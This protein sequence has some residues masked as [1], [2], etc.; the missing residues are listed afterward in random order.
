[1][2]SKFHMSF[3]D[4]LWFNECSTEFELLRFHLGFLR[5]IDVVYK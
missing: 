4:V 3:F 5:V 1:M 2:F